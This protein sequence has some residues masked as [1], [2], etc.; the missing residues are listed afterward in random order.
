MLGVDYSECEQAAVL[1]KA[2]E[3][4]QKGWLEIDETIGPARVLAVM[5]GLSVELV[6]DEAPPASHTGESID[7]SLYSG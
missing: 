5:D 3:L 1:A 2:K 6:E 7:P 4:A